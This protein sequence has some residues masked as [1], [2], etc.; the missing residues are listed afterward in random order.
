MKAIVFGDP[1]VK[2]QTLE[3]NKRV[4]DF[5]LK[6]VEERKPDYVINLGDTFHT[7]NTV[8]TSALNLY[9]NFILELTK[10]TKVIQ[11]IGNHD[12]AI[13]YSAHPFSVFKH[14]PNLTIV[15]KYFILED[16]LFMAYAREKERLQTLMEEAIATSPKKLV[17]MFGHLDIH[18]FMPGDDW[19]EYSPHVSPEFFSGFEQV[20]SGHY[21]KQQYKKVNNTEIIFVGTSYTTDF[22]ESDQEKRIIEIDLKTGNIE[23]IPTNF[24]FHKTLH[25]NAGDKF[26]EIPEDRDPD[27]QYRVIVKGTYEEINSLIL[28]KKYPAII[29]Y[30]FENAE[31]TRIELK[32]TDT[33]EDILKKYITA[34]IERN[35]GGVDKAG[36]EIEKLIRLSK[37]YIPN[38]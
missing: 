15:D 32:S 19:V 22:G 20:I 3:V 36:F 4:F 16:N 11:L 23:D 38:N 2:P 35:Y 37:R 31:G 21:H 7:K 13:E 25:I 10:K 30:D 14:I 18:G 1:H 33:Q 6:T 28:P 5:I 27:S 34:E 12:W 29:I 17:R 9:E 24:T 8:Y 26:P